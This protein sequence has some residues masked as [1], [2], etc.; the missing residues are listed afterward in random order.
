MPL[1]LGFL[2]GLLLAAT[3]G[4]SIGARERAGDYPER[5]R[6]LGRYLGRAVRKTQSNSLK[7]PD[8]NLPTTYPHS[9]QLPHKIERAPHSP[10]CS[11]D[12]RGRRQ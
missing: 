2:V 4:C 12:R 8:P 3:G 9:Y 5:E 7:I 10:G 11:A 6:D 1:R